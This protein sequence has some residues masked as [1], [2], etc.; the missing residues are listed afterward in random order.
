MEVQTLFFFN[1]KAILVPPDLQSTTFVVSVNLAERLKQNTAFLR[2]KSATS[3]VR[4]FFRCHKKNVVSFWIHVNLNPTLNSFQRFQF[5]DSDGKIKLSNKFH[6][7]FLSV[8]S[9]QCT[10]YIN[11]VQYTYT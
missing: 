5:K 3:F 6:P 1:I 4:T 11:V 7:S 10:V 9:V 2:H 8:C